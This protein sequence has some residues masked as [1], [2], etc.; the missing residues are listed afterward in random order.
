MRSVSPDYDPAHSPFVIQFALRCR[1]A[2]C[3]VKADSKIDLFY[4]KITRF[5][6]KI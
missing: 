1:C 5:D 6:V 2:F 3:A 4:S